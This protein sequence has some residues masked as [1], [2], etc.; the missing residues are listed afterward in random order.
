VEIPRIT[1]RS[2][3]HHLVTPDHLQ[4]GIISREYYERFTY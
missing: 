1:G 3:V 2:T 4:V